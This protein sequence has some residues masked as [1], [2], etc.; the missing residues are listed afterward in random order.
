MT[1]ASKHAHIVIAV[2]VI[3][4]LIILIA[5]A[6]T[7]AAAGHEHVVGNSAAPWADHIRTLDE[8][9]AKKNISAA[10][11]AFH[12]AYLA[13]LGSRRWEGMVEVGDASLRVGAVSGYRKVSETTARRLYLQAFVRA[14]QQGSIDGLL[15]TAEAFSRLG[16]REVADQGL[17]LAE[18]LAAQRRDG[19][20]SDRAR[21][22]REQAAAR[23]LDMKG[24]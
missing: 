21:A 14:R 18:R 11:H 23:S 20:A 8:A 1:Q 17:R 24:P 19:R 12:Q 9:L 5:L 10:E 15:R 4:M 7:E 22:F 6:I 16:D 3:A 2:V 13:A